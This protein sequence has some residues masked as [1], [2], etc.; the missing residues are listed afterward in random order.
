M[1]PPQVLGHH[2]PNVNGACEYLTLSFSPLRAPLRSRW[3]NNGL[4][5]DFLSDYVTTFLPGSGDLAN[6]SA[7][8]KIRHAVSY[9]S[10]E[11]LENA[12]KYH[13]NTID[14]P[15][16]IDMELTTEHIN[17]KA[18]NGVNEVQAQ[19]YKLFIDSLMSDDPGDLMLRT[20]ERGVDDDPH[21][22]GLGLLT[23]MNDYG[24]D[25][26]WHFDSSPGNAS[27]ETVT[28]SVILTL[29]NLYGS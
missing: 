18:S 27:I 25:L 6:E 15:I 21:T 11:L 28:T 14:V 10:N 9:V 24:A 2:R 4:S 19:R 17:I 7:H 22:S 26:A 20:L 13:E 23:M 16:T 12:M 1:K 3:R 29:T 5:A 8:N